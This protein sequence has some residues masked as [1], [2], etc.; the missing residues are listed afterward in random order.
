ME[1]LESHE[2]SIIQLDRPCD[3][4]IVQLF[5]RFGEKM[6][7]YL[8]RIGDMK[9]R[10]SAGKVLREGIRVL[11]CQDNHGLGSRR[12]RESEGSVSSTWGVSENFIE[13]LAA[14]GATP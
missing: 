10:G 2:T 9:A 14:L 8:A 7:P 6:T 5:V 13:M 3:D 12:R 4:E 1:Q 11:S